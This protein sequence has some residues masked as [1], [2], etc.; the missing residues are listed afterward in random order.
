MT[1]ESTRREPFIARNQERPLSA[2]TIR[3]LEEHQALKQE[4][5]DLRS[6]N[7]H[8]HVDLE[9]A[10]AKNQWLHGELRRVQK[11]ADSFQ[12]GFMVLKVSAT[13]LTASA[14]ALVEAANKEVA[15]EEL[16][17]DI[18]IGEQ[19]RQHA[20]DRHQGGN[21]HGP[22]AVRRALNLGDEAESQNA[23]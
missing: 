10:Q 11:R 13:S 15:E 19:G 14:L 23:G 16:D 21:G 1:N 7:E 18:S 22:E 6:A 2:D 9:A 17:P 12:R 3:H 20:D 5:A 8:L 4:V